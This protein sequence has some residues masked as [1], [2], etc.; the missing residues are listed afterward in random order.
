MLP[1]IPYSGIW[2]VRGD[3]NLRIPI[4]RDIAAVFALSNN[5]REILSKVEVDAG[6]FGTWS[7][8]KKKKIISGILSIVSK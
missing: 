6:S 1:S 5:D 8:S 4:I 7:V 3:F 2:P